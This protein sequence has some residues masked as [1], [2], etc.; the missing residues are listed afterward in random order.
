MIQEIK[1][2]TTLIFTAILCSQTYGQNNFYSNIKDYDL[3]SVYKPNRIVDYSGNKIKVNEPLG[4]IDDQFQRFQIHFTS[5]K[6][7]KTNRYQY[8]VVGKT[9]VNENICSF[10]GTFKVM[11]AELKKNDETEKI[12][13][14]TYKQVTIK[15]EITLFE[16]KKEVGSGFIKGTLTTDLYIND[17]GKLF[18]DALN[19]EADGFSNNQFEGKWT[20]YKTNKSKKCNWGDYRIPN[21]DDFDIGAG[22][23]SVDDKYVKNG[24]ENYK[25]AWGTYPETP[26]VIEARRKENKQ[27]WK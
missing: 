11:S 22:E 8:E 21:S 6:K 5:I 17:S 19:F 10:K 1:K 3:A 25:L 24:W 16:N 4:F 23:F 12:D 20:S 26:E 18:Y 15:S 14:P 27:W 2:I 13:V 9:K 7:S